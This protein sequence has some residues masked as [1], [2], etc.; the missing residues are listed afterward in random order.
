VFFGRAE[1][2]GVLTAY[3]VD[4]RGIYWICQDIYEQLFEIFVSNLVVVVK[5]V[6]GICHKQSKDERGGTFPSWK[7]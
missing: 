5:N 6:G 1:A 7:V 2:C 4:K 3:E